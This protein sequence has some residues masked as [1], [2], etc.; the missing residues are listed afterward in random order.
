MRKVLSSFLIVL[1]FISGCIEQLMPQ[2]NKGPSYSNNAITIEDY[3]VSVLNPYAGSVT[4][5]EFLVQN[6]I[7][8][9]IDNVIVN[10][11]NIPGGFTVKS[12]R[13]GTK[14]WD[15][16]RA[17]CTFPEIRSLDNKKVRITLEADPNIFIETPITVNFLVKY[18][19]HGGRTI[20]IPIID[21]SI[22]TE[23]VIKHS[24]SANVYSPVIIDFEPPIGRI[25]KTEK[26]TIKEYWG[27]KDTPF[28]LKVKFK[29]VGTEGRGSQIDILN[30]SIQLTLSD[31]L[32]VENSLPCDFNISSI[33][34]PPASCANCHAKDIRLLAKVG[35]DVNTLSCNFKDKGF[36][37]SQILATVTVTYD[38]DYEFIKSETFKVVPKPTI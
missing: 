37:T 9:T 16:G 20:T 4:S 38:Y 1:I 36:D 15:D 19:A 23:P 35:K 12:I 5:I 24:E 17:N 34:P 32:E 28:E 11:F 31:N 27:T 6:N 33:N 13:C 2:G 3:H 22:L 8:R 7:D 21:S 18:P 10:F 25:T 26:Q 14:E 29:H 30:S